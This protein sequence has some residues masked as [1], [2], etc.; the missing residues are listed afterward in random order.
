VPK[1]YRYLSDEMVEDIYGSCMDPGNNVFDM[2][3]FERLCEEQVELFRALNLNSDSNKDDPHDE[4][5]IMMGDHYWTVIAKVKVPLTHPFD[6]PKPFSDRLSKLRPNNRIRVSRFM[7]TKEPRPRTVWAD[8]K[9]ES[10]K[11]VKPKKKGFV[12]KDARD[13]SRHSD[14]G[15]FITSHD[16]IEQVP[17]KTAYP[18]QQKENKSAKKGKIKFT[19][20]MLPP[21]PTEPPAK[22]PKKPEKK[23]KPTATAKAKV[24]A[25]MKEF[26]VVQPPAKPVRTLDGVSPMACLKQL[27]DIGMIGPIE[28]DTI[29]PSQSGY[30]AFDP[31]NHECI[32]LVVQKASDP[33]NAV[34]FEDL[35]YEQDRDVNAVS[36]QVIKHH[37]AALALCDITGPQ[38]KW[39]KMNFKDLRG[40]LSEKLTKSSP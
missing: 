12:D 16:T 19:V 11:T 3:K 18:K 33:E 27:E 38:L 35:R 31:A 14:P 2:K 22:E 17:Y 5:R 24:A 30:A 29:M 4:R 21:T 10:K 1:P 20:K 23:K 9:S 8:E 6:P 40:H 34:L 25:R 39:S 7:A 37:L 15:A 26:K 36:K 28:W 32:R 13:L